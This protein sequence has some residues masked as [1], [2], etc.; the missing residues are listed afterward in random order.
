MERNKQDYT[1]M[2]THKATLNQEIE[3]LNI[4]KEQYLYDGI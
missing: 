2:K 3:N 4:L 1:N